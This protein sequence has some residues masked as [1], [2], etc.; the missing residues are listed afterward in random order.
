MAKKG[1]KLEVEATCVLAEQDGRWR[2]R[3]QFDSGDWFQSEQD[4][5]SREDAE[6]AFY[7]WRR[8]VGAEIMTAQ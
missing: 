4:F 7:K 5:A 2:I 3:I 8:E 6:V 1:K